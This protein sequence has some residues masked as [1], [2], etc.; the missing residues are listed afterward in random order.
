M[1]II[2]LVIWNKVWWRDIPCLWAECSFSTRSDK[3]SVPMMW[4]SLF[5]RSFSNKKTNISTVDYLQN[6]LFRQDIRK[7]F[8]HSKRRLTIFGCFTN[9]RKDTLVQIRL[10]LSSIHCIYD[11]ATSV[12]WTN[13]SFINDL[14]RTPNMK[15]KK[16]WKSL[17]TLFSR[18]V[19]LCSFI[20]SHAIWICDCRVPYNQVT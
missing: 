4:P 8:Y 10:L 6:N 1:L 19:A 9:S 12:L 20:R 17:F 5:K 15:D 11:K 18:T 7:K 16:S 2:Y 13:I 3:Y 14:S